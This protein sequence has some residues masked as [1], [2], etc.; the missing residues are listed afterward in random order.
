LVQA[1]DKF[2]K[3]NLR[4]EVY[5]IGGGPSNS[6]LLVELLDL[7]ETF[8]NKNSCLTYTDWRTADQKVYISNIT[9]AKEILK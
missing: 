9:K 7:I 6:L 8:R 5:N 2:L 3:S 1:F 4:H